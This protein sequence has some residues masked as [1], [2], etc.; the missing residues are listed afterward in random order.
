MAEKYCPAKDLNTGVPKLP[1]NKTANI[2]P[3]PKLPAGAPGPASK[4]SISYPKQVG[5]GK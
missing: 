2:G 1:V 5:K 3:G 4:G